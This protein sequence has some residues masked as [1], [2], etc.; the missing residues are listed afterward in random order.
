MDSDDVVRTIASEVLKRL[1][2]DGT[3]KLSSANGNS[4]PTTDRPPLSL[5]SRSKA[6]STQGHSLVLM[7]G[8]D[9]NLDHALS[10][11]GRI[12]DSCEDT[13]V[14]LSPTASKVVGVPAVRR[15]APKAK[16][17]MDGDV[18]NILDGV[19]IVYMPN[20]SLN[21]LA[22]IGRLT[23]DS[24]VCILAVQALLRGIPVVVS[25]DSL[26]PANADESSVPAG[27]QER[28]DRMLSILSDMGV[29]VRSVDDLCKTVGSASSSSSSGTCSVG[30]DCEGCGLC[31]DKNPVA[32]QAM[33]DSG[34]DRVGSSL[35]VRPP[36][37]KSIARMI[38]HTL[39]RADATESDI[40]KLCE[41]AR[42]YEFA[43]VCVNPGWVSLSAE[44]LA[45]SPV[46]VCTVIGFPLGATTPTAKAIET[47]DAI[48]NGANEI[49]M[50]INVGA[51]KSGDD[52]L[53]KRDIE[54]VVAAA[55]NRGLVK[56]IIETA[57]LSRE[58]KVKACLLAK[59]AGADFVKTSTGFST[60]G[61]T[62]EDIALMR[63]TVG[64]DM[65]VKASGGIK[66][67]QTAEAMKAAGATRIG[68]SAS[69]AIATGGSSGS[70][71]Y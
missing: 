27:V 35:G 1:A 51:L 29:S 5:T 26:L 33:V 28:I 11:L 57:L 36:A 38:D 17:L 14:V 65:G 55:K 63:Q 43:S 22:K 44:L 16:I 41:E 40:R 71:G 53:V 69:V 32:V 20:M 48:A 47:R 12:G 68:A 3:G 10:Q 23:P 8:G 67:R 6:S 18:E 19:T 50:V 60:G 61:A 25:K 9:R 64:P 46:K 49:D 56:V 7:T 66:D 59:M 42:Q 21:A 58:E 39:L 30:D 45:Q 62:V 31:L 15:A 52:E 4:A 24:M 70:G 37:D 2:A 13:T 34:A 54:G